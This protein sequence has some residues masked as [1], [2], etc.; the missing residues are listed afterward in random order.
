MELCHL[1]AHRTGDKSEEMFKQISRLPQAYPHLL[2]LAETFDNRAVIQNNFKLCVSD[3][4]ISFVFPCLPAKQSDQPRHG[5]WK[6]CLSV[7]G[8]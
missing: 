8:H 1:T 6:S 5:V 3:G 2:I 4:K 7:T